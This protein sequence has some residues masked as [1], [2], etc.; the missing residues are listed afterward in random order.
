ML[1]GPHRGGAETG[2][3]DAH[4]PDRRVAGVEALPEVQRWCASLLHSTACSPSW[5]HGARRLVRAGA[6]HR[7]GRP[8]PPPARLR[9][10]LPLQQGRLRHRT[11]DSSW[12]HLDLGRL[13][14]VVKAKLRRST[15]RAW[16]AHRGRAV[17]S[18]RVRLHPR[19]RG[20]GGVA[21]HQ[22][23]QDRGPPAPPGRLADGRGDLRSGGRRPAR[24]GPAGG[25]V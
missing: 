2:M 24:P 14:L 19:L 6:D 18:G 21:G 25:A 11:V 1:V 10:L 9:G 22:D 12:R 3:G 17:R 7:H 8:A 15:A 16:G 4:R 23:G 13:R 5:Y 20:P